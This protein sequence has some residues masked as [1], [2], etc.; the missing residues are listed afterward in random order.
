MELKYLDRKFEDCR[1]DKKT[2]EADDS[3][4]QHARDFLQRSFCLE[5]SAEC[6]EAK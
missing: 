6:R 3:K 1:T 2:G 4:A 5:R